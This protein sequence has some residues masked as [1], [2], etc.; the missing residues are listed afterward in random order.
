MGLLPEPHRSS[1][2]VIVVQRDSWAMCSDTCAWDSPDDVIEKCH[3]DEMASTNGLFC[4]MS[5][6]T[7]SDDIPPTQ[8]SLLD[9]DL[10]PGSCLQK[11][12]SN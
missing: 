9:Q 10:T 1:D 12:I 7:E 6:V 4:S 3:D 11:K 5:G 2:V 8:S